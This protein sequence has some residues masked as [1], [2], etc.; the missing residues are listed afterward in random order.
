MSN[1]PNVHSVDKSLSFSANR[2]HLLSIESHVTLAQDHLTRQEEKEEIKERPSSHKHTHT[3]T[4][5]HTYIYIYH[6]NVSY[7]NYTV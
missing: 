3:H 5:T 4:H 7:I 6:Y 2:R 1:F